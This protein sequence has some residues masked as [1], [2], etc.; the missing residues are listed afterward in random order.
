INPFVLVWSNVPP[1]DYVLTAL[2]TD[3]DG[4]STKSDPVQIKVAEALPLPIVTVEATDPKASEGPLD[5]SVDPVPNTATFTIKR[6]GPTN[7]SLTVYYRLGGTASN[8]VDY[9]Q[10]RNHVTIPAGSSSA[11]VIID[12][13]DDNLVEGPET[14]VL[15]LVEP[16]CLD[17]L[18]PVPT[19]DCYQLG[20]NHTARAIIYDNDSPPNQPPAVRIV[21]PEDGEIF[22]APADIRISAAA[23]DLDGHVVSVEFF[24]GTNSLGIV[25]R[26][27]LS[28][29]PTRQLFELTWSNV[30]GGEYVLSAVATDD[31]GAF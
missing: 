31:D 20:R 2:A 25:T 13:I 6:R 4:A 18:S 8:G 23:F 14:V 30:A 17:V 15:A 27:S 24:E 9:I 28:T 19:G 11:D 16:P 12:P 7:D 22:L 1:G 10:L 29:D 21:K 3:N 5:P 26:P